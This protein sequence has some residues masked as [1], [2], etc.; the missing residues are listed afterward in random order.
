MSLKDEGQDRDVNV[1]VKFLLENVTS[2]F[3]SR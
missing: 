3:F 2:T 1:R